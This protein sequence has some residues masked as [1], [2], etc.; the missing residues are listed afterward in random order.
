[1]LAHEL[2]P[3]LQQ[4][5]ALSEEPADRVLSG[6]S[7]GGLALRAASPTIIRNASARC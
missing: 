1:M 3:W 5:Y 7:Y 6:S 4:R 2:L